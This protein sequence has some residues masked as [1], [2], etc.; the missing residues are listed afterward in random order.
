MVEEAQDVSEDSWSIL[1]PTIRKNQSEIWLAWNPYLDTDPTQQRF[2][3]NPHPDS[4]ICSEFVNYWLRQAGVLL[5]GV[6]QDIRIS[7]QEM[8]GSV[9]QW[10]KELTDLFG[11][12]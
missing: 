9:Q 7:P 5:D 4:F 2:I 6:V 8:W 3:I 10:G 1:I 11:G 12:E